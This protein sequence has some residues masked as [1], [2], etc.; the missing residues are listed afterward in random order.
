MW[1][2]SGLGGVGAT[3]FL[4]THASMPTSQEP[5][6]DA[7]GVVQLALHGELDLATIEPVRVAVSR[8][9][10]AGARHV[11]FDLREVTFVDSSALALFSQTALEVEVTIE[12][13]S[14]LIRRTIEITGLDSVLTVTP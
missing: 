14:N 11:V 3:T 12:Q 5:E 6:V 1:P 2:E 9:V 13:P 10:A 8:A 7:D 4:G